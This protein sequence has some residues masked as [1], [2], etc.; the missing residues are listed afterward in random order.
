MPCRGVVTRRSTLEKPPQHCDKLLK[1]IV[2]HPMAGA[3]DGDHLRLPE[4]SHATVLCRIGGPALIAVD[5]QRR[6]GDASPELFHLGVGHVVG[7]P[8]SH[9]VVELPA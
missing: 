4:M 3:S 9:I 1:T 7:R 6:A 5:E 8:R 2:V